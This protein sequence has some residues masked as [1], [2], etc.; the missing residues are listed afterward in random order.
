MVKSR[1][2]AVALFGP[3]LLLSAGA[4]LADDT[5]VGSN[6]I[7]VQNNLKFVNQ[8][9]GTPI[10]VV[11][12]YTATCNVVFSGVTLRVPNGFTPK[13]V[14]G[15]IANVTGP[16]GPGTSGE[17]TFDLTFDT[18]KQAGKAKS[19]GMAHLSLALGADEDCNP[20]TGDANGVD[21]SVTIPLQ[22]SASTA[23]HP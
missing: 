13:G 3:S 12:D 1:R 7:T 21:G 5:T 10:H 15:S 2:F 8:T 4:A 23:S 20:A 14:S 11:L 19:F 9:A 16:A 6:T 18:L 17:V 22:V